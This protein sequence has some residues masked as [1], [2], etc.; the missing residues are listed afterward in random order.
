[1]HDSEGELHEFGSHWKTDNCQDCSCFRE[2]ITCC[3]NF[4]TPVGY[5]ENK[6]VRIFNKETCTYKVVEKDDD[7]KECP[8]HQWV[9]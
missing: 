2:G 3:S 1:C 4:A 5:D 8:V 7:S 9:A 6:C